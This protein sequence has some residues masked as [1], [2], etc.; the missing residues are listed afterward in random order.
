MYAE[1]IFQGNFL[2]NRNK[3]APKT[4]EKKRNEMQI[5]T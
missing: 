2:V 5:K 4:I 1:K 3:G